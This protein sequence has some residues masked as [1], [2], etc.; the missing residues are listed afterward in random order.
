MTEQ[1]D[2]PHSSVDVRD[3]KALR[4]L[5]HPLRL[6]LLGVLRRDGAHSVGELSELVDA[7]PGSVSYH[8][9]TLERFGFVVEAPELARDGRERWWR[10]A[11]LETHFDPGSLGEDPGT[12]AAAR[13]MRATIY[14]SYLGE[15]LAYLDAEPALERAWVDAATSGDTIAYLT[16]DETR[17]L[18]DELEALA[19]RWGA[20]RDAGRAGVAPVRLMYSTFRQP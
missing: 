13:A 11:H 19:R 8:L 5:A 12:A 7:A 16:A 1:P 15:Q 18:S 14:Q 3:P 9:G 10:A 17:K 4:A 6:A 20:R 2:A